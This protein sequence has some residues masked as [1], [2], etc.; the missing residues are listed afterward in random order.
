M[1]YIS[2]YE[3]KGFA[4]HTRWLPTS[5][6]SVKKFWTSAYGF[7]Y[8]RVYDPDTPSIPRASHLFL[9]LAFSFSFIRAIPNI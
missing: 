5:C 1:V 4:R 6:L 2:V 3:G 8:V 9:M 7:A